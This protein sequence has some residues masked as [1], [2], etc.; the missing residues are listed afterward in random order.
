MIF[1]VSGGVGASGDHL[2]RTVLAQFGR[3]DVV[4]EVVPHVRSTAQVDA[5]VDRVA[6]VGGVLVHTMV[7]A[8]LRQE[9]VA[10]GRGRRRTHHR[11][12]GAAVGA[13]GSVARQH[14]GR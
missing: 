5:V 8:A 4:I 10:Q 3:A 13:P 14:S 7:D 12:D 2:V 6:A 11:S 1:V 9:L